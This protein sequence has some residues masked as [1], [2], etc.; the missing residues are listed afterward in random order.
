MAF[1]ASQAGV[2]AQ[3]YFWGA[4]G[5]LMPPKHVSL[6][7][8]YFGA[9]RSAQASEAGRPHMP[10]FLRRLGAPKASEAGRP[11]VVAF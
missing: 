1:K 6:T 2:L 4:R 3:Q 10:V 11:Q 7:C 5:H 9:P 8:Q